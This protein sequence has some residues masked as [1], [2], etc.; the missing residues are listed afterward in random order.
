MPDVAAEPAAGDVLDEDAAGP[1]GGDFHAFVQSRWSALVRY[2]YLLTGDLGH[3]EDLVQVALE[4]TWRRWRHVRAVRPEVYVRTA[5]AR[6]A[7]SRG[8]MLRRRVRE[9]E[10]TSRVEPPA[11]DPTEAS[12]AREAVWRELRSLPPRMRAVVVLRVWEDLSE[13]ET[14]ALLGC[15]TGAVKSQL[16]RAVDRLA[17]RSALREAVGLPGAV[18][19]RTAGPMTKE[20]Q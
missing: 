8:R 16:S 17:G 18:D 2:A 14:A 3:A 11:P 5:I 15:S 13:A 20:D 6:R 9:A 4:G 7:V 19:P 10:L 1:D 12:A